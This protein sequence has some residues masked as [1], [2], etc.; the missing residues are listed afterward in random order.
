MTPR[1]YLAFKG[2]IGWREVFEQNMDQGLL[3]ALLRKLSKA[4]MLDEFTRWFGEARLKQ[5]HDSEK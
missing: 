5:S 2:I 3:N 4:G 1:T